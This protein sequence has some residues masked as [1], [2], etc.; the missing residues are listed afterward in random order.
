[1]T[2]PEG[3]VHCEMMDSTYQL[4]GKYLMLRGH[5]VSNYE[6]AQLFFRWLKHR[7][8]NSHVHSIVE[9]IAEKV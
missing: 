3:D 4:I 2:V 9:A 8:I 1:M 7:G 6:N 5:G